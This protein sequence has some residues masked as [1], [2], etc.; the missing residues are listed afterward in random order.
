M[1]QG[2]LLNDAA[3]DQYLIGDS[4]YPLLPWLM[5]PY[6]DAIPG[7]VEA[8]FNSALQV[9]RLPA[10]RTVASLRNWGVLSRPVSEDVKMVVAYIG[11]CSILHNGLLMREDFSALA[12]GFEDSC[13]G[14]CNMLQEEEGVSSKALAL[15]DELAKKLRD[16]KCS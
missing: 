12:S 15:R 8:D 3:F 7:S 1:Q 11:A 13:T 5:V 9:M 14:N 16:S 4:R 10:L 2:T 6:V